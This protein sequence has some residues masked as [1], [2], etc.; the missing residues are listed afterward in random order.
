MLNNI[1]YV[2][3]PD[4]APDDVNKLRDD[5]SK[6][7]DENRGLKERLEKLEQGLERMGGSNGTGAAANQPADAKA[8]AAKK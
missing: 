8:E 4:I 7:E 2:S 1:H 5:L 6:L 3:L